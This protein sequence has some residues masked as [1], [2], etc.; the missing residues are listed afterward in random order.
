VIGQAKWDMSQRC[1]FIIGHDV[2]VRIA[3]N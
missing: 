1:V 2:I 3:K